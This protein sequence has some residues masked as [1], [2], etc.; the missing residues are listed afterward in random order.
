M[1]NDRDRLALL[2]KAQSAGAAPGDLQQVVSALTPLTLAKSRTSVP[3]LYAG[4]RKKVVTR[5][6]VAAVL[7]ANVSIFSVQESKELAVAT[8]AF[9]AIARPLGSLSNGPGSLS[10]IAMETVQHSSRP[11]PS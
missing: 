7:L 3:L 6:G 9:W 5:V 8:C 10:P 4:W 2:I 1:P 11:A